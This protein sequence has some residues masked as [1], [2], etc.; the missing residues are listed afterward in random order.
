MKTNLLAL[1][2][3]LVTAGAMAEE[4]KVADVVL[5]QNTTAEIQFELVN[6]NV[7]FDAFSF[8]V[9]LPDGVVPEMETGTDDTPSFIAGDRFVDGS[10]IS[11]NL[12]DGNIIKF[13]RLT[14]GKPIQGTS[15][16]LFSAVVKVDGELEVGTQLT[17]TVSEVSFTTPGLTKEELDPVTFTITIG[18]PDD[19]R[20]KFDET[21]TSAPAAATG[22][23]VRVKRTIKANEWST[24]CLPFAM[25]EEQMKAAFGEDVELADFTSWASE[26]DD[27]GNIVGISVGFEDV[28]EMEAN[29]PYIIK[30]ASPVEEFTADGVDIEPEEEPTVQVGKKKAERGFFIG[31]Y[32]AGTE[33]PQNDLFLS[34]NQ[35]WYSTGKTK[36][37][38]FRAYFEFADVLTV[39]EEAA[40]KVRFN[41]GGAPTAIE[42]IAAG[43]YGQD[44]A[45]YDLSG[46]RLSVSSASSALPKGLYIV[47]GKKVIIK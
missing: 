10:G 46:R 20:I 25:N 37:K 34:G 30:V 33:V 2:M 27:E 32:V 18:E 5:P 6:P 45:V 14:D 28:S 3:L 1:A 15:G 31:T 29:H 4:L 13:A 23:D 41:I 42:G 12:V 47:N 16:V 7:V 24:I 21:S 43:K 39:V 17:A 11:S 36:M 44:G 8:S 19:G 35:F 26:E 22:V 40:A 9:T 38:A